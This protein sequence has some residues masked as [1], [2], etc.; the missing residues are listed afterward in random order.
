MTLSQELTWRGFTNQTTYKDISVLDGDPITFYLGMD[1]S[2]DSLTIGNLAVAMMIRHF[3]DHGHRAIMLVGGATGL[4]GDPDGKDDERLLKSHEEVTAYKT[5]IAA[6]YDRIF[7]GQSFEHVDNYDWFKDIGY[8]EFLRDV[9][10]HVPMSQMLGRQFVQDRLGEMGSG[11]SYAE[12]SYALIQGYDFLHLYRTKGATLQL[13]GSDQW[14]NSIAGVELIRRIEGV[15][16]NIWSVPL[17][18]NKATGKKFGKSEGGAVWLDPTKTTPTAFYQFW[19]NCDDDGIEDY[20]K[21]YTMLPRDELEDIMTKHHQNPAERF[22]QRRVAE[23]VTRLIHG[24]EAVRIAQK[25]TDVLTGR[26]PV[27]EA[28]DVLAELRL[29]VPTAMTHETGSVISALVD[30]GLAQS[31]GQAR[32]LLQGNAV[33]VNGVKLTDENF[34]PRLF[35]SGRLLL[36]RGKA[37]KDSALIE[38]A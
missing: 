26:L 17:V 10:K 23:E 18:V 1:P 19:I 28:G 12:F 5:K 13:C 36:R 6:Q 14:G 8:L 31:N 24:D 3:I 29:E 37:Y 27:A 15:E 21:I 33:S 22:A 25:V 34:N 9:G 2:A 7:A 35:Q 16:A 32:R 30:S 38:L 4:I 11:L 20:A